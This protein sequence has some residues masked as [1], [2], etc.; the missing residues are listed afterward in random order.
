MRNGQ[1]AR[2]NPK[3]LTASLTRIIAKG[4]EESLSLNNSIISALS[5]DIIDRF[6]RDNFNEMQEILNVICF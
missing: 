4:I 6:L 2:A 5:D 1:K 3:I